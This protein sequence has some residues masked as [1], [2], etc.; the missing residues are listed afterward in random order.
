MLFEVGQWLV[1]RTE[2]RANRIAFT[3]AVGFV[4]GVF[5]A[6]LD[7]WLRLHA[8]ADWRLAFDAGSVGLLVASLTYI[9]VVAVQIRRKRVA[10]EIQVV[11]ELN[12]NVR[13]A[14]QAISYAVRLP[15]TENQVEIIENC[16]QR[17]DAT[18]RDL[19][20][21]SAP[22]QSEVDSVSNLLHH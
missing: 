4:A 6:V 16:V 7:S 5:E 14:L 2:T 11:A 12:H 19:F 8:G 20:P 22:R 3:V 21:S 9:E 13:N 18:L 15:E 1:R 17:I 10:S